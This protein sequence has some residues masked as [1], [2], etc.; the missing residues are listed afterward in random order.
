MT[1]TQEAVNAEWNPMADEW[2]DVASEY[3]DQFYKILWE[4]G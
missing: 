1:T 4:L 2:D 3:Q